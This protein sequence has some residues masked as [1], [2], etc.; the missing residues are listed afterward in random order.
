M[1]FKKINHLIKSVPH[2][3]QSIYRV[4]SQMTAIKI[5]MIITLDFSIYIL[6]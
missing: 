4:I 5:L 3:I 1:K 6:S 2:N